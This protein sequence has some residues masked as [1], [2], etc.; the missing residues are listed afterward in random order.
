MPA[1]CRRLPWSAVG[2]AAGS[3]ENAEGEVGGAAL[4]T[5]VERDVQVD[6]VPACEIEGQVVGIARALELVEAPAEDGLVLQLGQ[7]DLDCL[8]CVFHARVNGSAAVGLTP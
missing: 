5:Q 3:V 8:V 7:L 4:R 1:P 6:V 2:L